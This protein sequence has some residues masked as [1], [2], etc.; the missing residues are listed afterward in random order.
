MKKLSVLSLITALSCSSLTHAGC[1]GDQSAQ[2]G[3]SA[4]ISL[5][6]GYTV[7][8]EED[9]HFTITGT[10]NTLSSIVENQHYSGR[11]A[12]GMMNMVDDQWG[13][14]GELGWGIYG[15]TTLNPDALPAFTGFG[16]YTIERTLTGLDALVGIAYVQSNFSVSF[17]AG[18]LIQNMTTTTTSTGN[19]VFLNFNIYDS[20]TYKTN[21]TA[22]LPEI[23][24][25]AAYNFD[26]NWALTAAYIFAYGG[27]S[28]TS[29]E[30]NPLPGR[31]TVVVDNL[32]PGM[33][34]LLVG[35]QYSV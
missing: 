19:F 25:G 3:A 11:L 15:T 5:E 4:F 35:I 21:Q 34:S 32:H 29:G 22:A 16:T 2:C 20:Y 24:L 12:A 7:T 14:T 9:Y 31:S 33:N 13:V 23:K 17:K 8:A 28:K 1:M 18:A 6:G 30:Y 10:N 27:T 26:N